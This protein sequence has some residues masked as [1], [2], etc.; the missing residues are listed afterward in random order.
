MKNKEFTIDTIKSI[1]KNFANNGILFSNERQFQLELAFELRKHYNVYLEMLD[2][3]DTEKK[4]V[5]IVVDVGNN[6]LVTIELKYTTRDRNILYKTSNRDVYTFK[7]GSNDTRCFD[8]LNDVMRLESLLNTS[9]VFGLKGKKI[10]KGFAV[11]MT[12]D[13][14]YKLDGIKRKNGYETG[15]YT[16]Y[17]QVA[18]NE[19]RIINANETLTIDTSGYKNKQIVLNNSYTCHWE[20]YELNATLQ[21]DNNGTEKEYETYPFRYMIFEINP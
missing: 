3:S 7:Q 6:E 9:N 11:I 18:L 8:Y 20:K 10:I 17:K 5:D 12:N 13:N 16:K 2:Y 15:E 4:Y 1:L 14:Y 19:S 21:L